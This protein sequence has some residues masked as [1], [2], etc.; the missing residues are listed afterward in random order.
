MIAESFVYC[1]ENYYMDI[2]SDFSNEKI[3]PFIG[4]MISDKYGKTLVTFEIVKGALEN[5]IKKDRNAENVNV[6]TFPT[7]IC[8]LKRLLEEN[9]I[10]NITNIKLE[11][12][13]FKMHILF[14]QNEFTIIFFL[15]PIVCFNVVENV[16]NNY[17]TNFFEEFKYDFEDVSFLERLGWDWLID[18]NNNYLKSTQI[19]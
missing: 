10:Q 6:D 13:N 8:A 9:N 2:I 19:N 17:L 3:P 5:I 11:N 7:Y 12:S 4:C 18:L 16:I 14:Y 1:E 15:N